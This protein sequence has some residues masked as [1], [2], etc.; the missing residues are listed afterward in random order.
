MGAGASPLPL[1]CLRA[2]RDARVLSRP[3]AYLFPR[4]FRL[5]CISFFLMIR[6]PPR[7]TL[8]PYTTL[9][10][11][12]HPLDADKMV[13]LDLMVMPGLDDAR[14]NGRQIGLAEFC[15]HPVVGPGAPQAPT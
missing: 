13:G 15:K 3:A 4:P 6:R 1:S 10:R 11:S 14:I 8:F 2:G 12:G 7:S 9:F 5:L